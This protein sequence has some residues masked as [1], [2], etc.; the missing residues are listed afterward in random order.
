MQRIS[1]ELAGCFDDG[2][3]GGGGAPGPTALLFSP[4]GKVWRVEVGRDGAGAFL[5]R[6]WADFLAAH[7]VGVGWF[8]LLRHAG[9]G[10]LTFKAF[11]TSFC[12]KEFAASAAGEHAFPY[13]SCN[14]RHLF[15]N[16]LGYRKD[17]YLQIT[18]L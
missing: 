15:R 1:D 6:G 14:L 3:G 17:Y 10:A 4:F 2:G 9:R 16:R 5:G 7:G 12:I 18:R 13:E 8:V 11:D